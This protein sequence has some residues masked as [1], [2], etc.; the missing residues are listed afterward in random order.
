MSIPAFH[1]RAQRS[2]A[3]QAGFT[4]AIKLHRRSPDC[5]ITT[6]MLYGI[7]FSTSLCPSRNTVSPENGERTQY[8]A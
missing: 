7:L 3:V 5:W 4:A 1:Q 2:L 8:D 6:D